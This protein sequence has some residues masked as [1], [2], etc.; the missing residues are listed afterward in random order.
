LFHSKNFVHKLA[1]QIVGLF[2]HQIS[3]NSHEEEETI[4]LL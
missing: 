1:L 2:G 4:F 3:V